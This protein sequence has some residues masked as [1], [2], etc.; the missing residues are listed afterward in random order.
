MAD[1]QKKILIIEDDTVISAMYQAKLQQ[2][3]YAILTAD[4]GA[5]GL[6]TAKEQKPDLIL[7]DVIIPQL[8]GFSVLQEL[9]SNEETKNIP[10][11]LLTNL[12]TSEDREKGNKLGALDYIVKANITPAQISE[13]VNAILK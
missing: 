6:K 3:G 4:N 9:K 12:S 13:K 2:S 7:L 10:V 5:D 11:I 8:D 1:G